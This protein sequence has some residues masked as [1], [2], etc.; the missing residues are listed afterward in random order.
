MVMKMIYAIVH[1]N[2]GTNVTKE[3]IANNYS[4]TSLSTTGGFFKK[5][6]QTLLIG[7]EAERVP[8][9]LALI[10]KSCGKRKRVHYTAPVMSGTLNSNYATPV[11]VT[12][13]IGGATI[14]V[15]DVERFEK[16]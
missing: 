16:I 7:T 11:P 9:A 12:V 14:F 6:N 1:A 3:L 8:Q 13:D 10:E 2:D 5:K 4:V 15:V